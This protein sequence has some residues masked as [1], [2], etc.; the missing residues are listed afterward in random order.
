MTGEEGARPVTAICARMVT[1]RLETSWHEVLSARIKQG[2]AFRKGRDVEVDGYG[3]SC[4]PHPPKPL[5]WLPGAASGWGFTLLL[6]VALLLT[7]SEPGCP[8]LSL[9]P[10][11]PV[12]ARKAGAAWVLPA[13]TAGSPGL[14]SPGMCQN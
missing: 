14:S 8:L 9:G 11:F 5:S 1:L 2:Q 12:S 3:A 6:S 7:P 4:P 13:L 10:G